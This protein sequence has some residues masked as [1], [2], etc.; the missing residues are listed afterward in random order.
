M[1]TI[2]LTTGFGY[3][4]DSNNKIISKY[5]LPRGDHPISDEFEFVEL[6]DKA[7]M[8]AV[9]IEPSEPEPQTAEQIREDKIQ[10]EIRAMAIERLE[11]RGEL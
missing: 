2:K 6:P 4:K 9:I 5:E 8:D 11:A 7:A 10:A 3:I 1:K